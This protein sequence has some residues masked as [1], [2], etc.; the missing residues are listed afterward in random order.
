MEPA[1]R[2]PAPGPLSGTGSAPLPAPAKGKTSTGEQ[3]TNS[4][5]QLSYTEVGAA[6]AVVVA[7]RTVKGANAGVDSSAPLPTK[8][9]DS[10]E[11]KG[12]RDVKISRRARPEIKSPRGEKDVTVGTT[13]GGHLV[14]H[15][16]APKKPSGPFKPTANGTVILPVSVSLMEGTLR[17]TSSGA[18]GEVSRP[19]TGTPAGTTTLIAQVDKAV[20]PGERRNKTP[21]YVSG[22]KQMKI[23][24]LGSREV[25][26]APGP[27]EGR[28][29]HAGARDGRWVP[30]HY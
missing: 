19:M 15:P 29:P 28:V 14:T 17:R 22:V 10:D 1:A 5:R 2:R 4:G 26:Q 9:G 7:W 8:D 3:A 16:A 25:R 30:S 18:P 11:G 20:P 13:A 23:P 21:V 6:Y 12:R 24:R 27:D